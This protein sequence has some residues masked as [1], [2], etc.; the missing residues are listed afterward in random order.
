MMAD[1]DEAR[2]GN[3]VQSPLAED[4]PVDRHQVTPLD[5]PA[6]IIKTEE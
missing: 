6:K 2:G 4:K 3:G 1:K 5:E